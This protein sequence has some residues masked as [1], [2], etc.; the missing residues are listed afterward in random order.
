[1]TAW[2]WLYQC[3]PRRWTRERLKSDYEV[4]ELHVHCTDVLLKCIPFSA[5]IL[6][7]VKFQPK[8]TVILKEF[9]HHCL[10][11]IQLLVNV[12]LF[13]FIFKNDMFVSWANVYIKLTVLISRL[14]V[15]LCLKHMLKST[16]SLMCSECP[17]LMMNRLMSTLYFKW[18]FLLLVTHTHSIISNTYPFYKVSEWFLL[19][20]KK[21]IVQLYHE[22]KLHNDICFVL[23]QHACLG[24]IILIPSQLV[25]TFS[26]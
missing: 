19:N 17:V 21:S 5:V 7:T 4:S 9:S 15:S 3:T 13:Y 8:F 22:N 14:V 26:P 6:L 11:R 12:S 24:H 18:L 25:L 20:A 16:T 1:M 23:D 2:Q 10:T